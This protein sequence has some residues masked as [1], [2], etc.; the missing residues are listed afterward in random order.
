MGVTDGRER[1]RGT[2]PKTVRNASYL[3]IYNTYIQIVQI[4]DLLPTDLTH[5]KN[6]I[7]KNRIFSYQSIPTSRLLLIVED[8]SL[9]ASGDGSLDSST[10]SVHR[11]HSF[12]FLHSV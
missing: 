8:A 11:S 12:C 6:I 4:S 3:N 5:S 2:C 10:T 7:R 1:K 9:V